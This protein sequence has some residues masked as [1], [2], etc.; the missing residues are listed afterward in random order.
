MDFKNLLS[1]L[2]RLNKNNSR[3]WMDR[4]RKQYRGLRQDF[5]QWLDQLDARL[6]DLDPD[7]YPTPGKRGINRINNNLMFHPNRPV[8][9]DHFGAGLDKAPG[10]GDFYVQIGIRE[11]LLAGGV[12]RPGAQDL[13][14]IRQAIDYDGEVLESILADP[15]FRKMFGNLYEDQR[16]I[17]MPKGF[18]ADHPHAELLKHKSFGVV[19]PLPAEFI[20]APDFEELIIATYMEML[21]FRR[22]LNRALS[23][24][25]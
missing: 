25:A 9:K 23:V 3:E 21:P 17:R 11:S 20:Y 5:I 10:T 13:S 12:W 24:E 19:R 4:H 1:F 8:Y 6:A 18:A 15:S 22:Y 14:K 16:L 2:E 7:Y